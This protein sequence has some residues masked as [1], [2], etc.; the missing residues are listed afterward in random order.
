MNYTLVD[1]ENHNIDWSTL[2][3]HFLVSLFFSF[4]IFFTLT[5]LLNFNSSPIQ[6]IITTSIAG[7]VSVLVLSKLF[8]TRLFGKKAQTILVSAFILRLIIGVSHFLF[9]IKTDYFLNPTVFNYLW[10][11]SS[12]H[13]LMSLVSQS[14][15]IQGLFSKLPESYYLANKNPFI[16]QF[17]GLLYYFSGEFVLNISVWNS[18]MNTFTA[19]II[20]LL[21]FLNTNSRK[22]TLVALVIVAF[23]PF[24]IVSSIVWRDSTGLFLIALAALLVIGF[25]DKLGI[26]IILLPL[27]AFIASWHRSPYL[28]IIL[29]L[30]LYVF[31]VEKK[32]SIPKAIGLSFLVIPLGFVFFGGFRNVF[33]SVLEVG[34]FRGNTLSRDGTYFDL[35]SLPVVLQLPV[36]L[37]K[38]IL[39]PFPWGQF[40][41]KVPG[42]EYQPVDYA[43]SVFNLSIFIIVF[44]SLRKSWKIERKIDYGFLFG[45]MIFFL[46]IMAFDVHVSYVAIAVPF[47]IPELTKVYSKEKFLNSIYVSLAIFIILHILFYTTGMLGRGYFRI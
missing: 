8:L 9:A 44:S 6:S 15:H 25:K 17:M 39:G 2:S 47:F 5:F 7:V 10:D 27:S 28:F 18:L 34:T 38:S 24:D 46:G 4:L 37:L 45:I 23:Q 31:K 21:T 26:A 14:W 11:F 43:T 32:I 35:I 42:F 22:N 29:F 40:F 3:I 20:G 19:T 16:I 33:Y 12:I 41:Q 13:E 1:N 36:R 30:F